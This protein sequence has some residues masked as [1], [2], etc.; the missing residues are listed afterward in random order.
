MRLIPTLMIA[1]AAL[2][3][4]AGCGTKTPLTR[5]TQAPQKTSLVP[6]AAQVMLT[7]VETRTGSHP[8][9]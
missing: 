3:A 8:W 6:P 5:P 7:A 2:A 1:A 4:L 9:A